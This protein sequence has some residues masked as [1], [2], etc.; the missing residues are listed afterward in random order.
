MPGRK[1]TCISS[2]RSVGGISHIGEY[3]SDLVCLSCERGF[4]D[5]DD[6]G[7]EVLKQSEHWKP[8][9]FDRNGVGAWEHPPVD[10]QRFR[11]FVLSVIWRAHA[12]TRPVFGRFSVGLH[13]GRIA[14]LIQ[15]RRSPPYFVFPMLLWRLDPADTLSSIVGMPETVKLGSWQA[16]DLLFGGYRFQVGFPGKRMPSAFAPFWVRHGRPLLTLGGN[17]REQPNLFRRMQ[18]TAQADVERN[19]VPASAERAGRPMGKSQ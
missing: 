17:I 16:A 18:R 9:A 4:S 13:A 7:Y 5:W 11:L 8:V 2:A 6:Y 14:K 12:S 19:G 10:F 15:A 3:D 1:S